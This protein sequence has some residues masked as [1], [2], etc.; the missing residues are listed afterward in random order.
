MAIVLFFIILFSII[1]GV[2]FAVLRVLKQTDSTMDGADLKDSLVTTAQQFLPY[3]DIKD[4]I[5]DLGSHK[6]RVILECSSTNYNLKTGQE[7]EIIE[8]SFQRFL[9][10][11]NFP[12]TFYVQTKVIDD[13]KM[14]MQLEED[15]VKTIDEYPNL[16]TYA[17]IYFQEMKNLHNYIGNNKAKRKYIIIPFED[18]DDLVNLNDKEKYEYAVKEIQTRAN[19]MI[20][21]LSTIGVKSTLLDNGD[22]IELIYSIYHKDDYTSVEHLISW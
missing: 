7:K 4:G 8:M 2:V 13:S 6:Y 17:D 12:I 20:D 16:Q 21:S 11:L 3:S 22:L 10:S 18:T 15:L 9:N 5:I 19:I 14:I 1:G